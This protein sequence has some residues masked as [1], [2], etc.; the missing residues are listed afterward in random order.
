MNLN[1]PLDALKADIANNPDGVLETLAT[2]HQLTMRH[3]LDCLPN[4]QAFGITGS[5]FEGIWNELT[6]WGTV[7]FIVHSEDGVF[8]FK[9]PIPNG[10]HGRGYFNVHGNSPLGGHI[11]ADRCKLIYFVDRLFFKRR[12]CS[13]QFINEDGN[14]MF[15][16]FVARDEKREMLPDQ[17]IAFETMRAH[18]QQYKTSSLMA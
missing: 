2:I 11:K 16:V 10:T 15:K 17:L 4:E 1:S 14:V 12:S 13:I 5:Y 7:M 8:E 3:V 9:A 6:N 18:Y